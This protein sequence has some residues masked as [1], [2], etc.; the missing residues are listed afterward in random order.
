MPDLN[1]A[2]STLLTILVLVAPLFGLIGLGWVIARWRLLHEAAARVL[3]EFAIKVAMP[4]LLFRAMLSLGDAPGPLLLIP[5]AYFSATVVMWLL[6]TAVTRLV[7]RRPLADAAPIGMATTFGNGVMLGFPLLTTVLGPQAAVPV[8]MLSALDTPLLWIIAT[9]YISAAERA[10]RR[11][12]ARAM[13]AILGDLARNTIVMSMLL[14]ALWNAGRL[15]LPG[16]IDR[17]LELLALA[18]VP[19]QLIALGMSLAAFEIRGQWPT[20]TAITVLKLAVYPLLAYLMA[21]Y[22]WSLPPAWIAILVAFAAMPVGANAFIFASKY[23]RAVG[24]VSAALTVS[25]IVSV[26]SITVVL[27]LVQLAGFTPG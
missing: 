19:I 11:L 2:F 1:A 26:I 7:L 4:A 6:A 23:E 12:D 22:A 27:A 17:V 21:A 13:L 5:A 25:T 14:G 3:S 15:P 20:L 18:A 24:S 16:P 8:A 9:L 10:G